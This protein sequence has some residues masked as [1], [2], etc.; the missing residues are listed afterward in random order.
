MIVAYLSEIIQKWTGWCP[1]RQ[2][3]RLAPAAITMPSTIHIPLEPDGSA[4]G[5]GRIGRGIE[6]FTGSVRTLVNEKR[7]LWFSVLFGVVAAFMFLALYAIRI[8]GS[9]P[10]G[11]I[12]YPAGIVL[13]CAIELVSIFCLGYLITGL[14]LSGSSGPTVMRGSIRGGLDE[15][16]KHLRALLYWSGILAITATALYFL[17][18]PAVELTLH[19]LLYR[20]PFGYIVTPEVYGQGPIAGEYHILHASAATFL[21]MVI[22]AILLVLTALVVPVLALDKKT[23]TGSI[24]EAIRLAKKS[25]VEMLVCVLIPGTIL[26]IFTALSGGFQTVF[27][28]SDLTSAG[29]FWYEF[30]YKGGWGVVAA[31]YITAWMA[32]VL[33]AATIFGIAVRN[34]YSWAK[35]GAVPKTHGWGN[36]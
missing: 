13:T 20:F 12:S 7:L 14:V 35:T 26:V 23:L 22:N 18:Q 2:M 10:Y 32:L 33:I 16:K 30:Y 34:I 1:N 21:L 19:S 28:A 27:N 5:S 24:I 36:D 29:S 15:A 17:V 9:Y 8:L 31:L 25:W 6:L 3:I 4:G 11:V